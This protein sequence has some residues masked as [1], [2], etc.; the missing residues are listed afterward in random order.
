MN[1]SPGWV[2][3]AATVLGLIGSGLF[4]WLRSVDA[5]QEAR[6]TEVKNTQKTLFDKHD[7]LAADLQAYK[8]HVAES[9]VNQAALEKL[10]LPIE[11]RLGSIEEDL[12]DNA[13]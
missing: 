7:K 5:A 9:Y 4:A 11:R 13:K 6:I 12:R 8:L 2:S 1:I 3:A 10:L